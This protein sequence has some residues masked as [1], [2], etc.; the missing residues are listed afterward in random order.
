MVGLVVLAGWAFVGL[1]AGEILTSLDRRSDTDPVMERVLAIT[2]AFVGG[3]AG[4]TLRL[5]VFGETLGFIFSAAGAAA[6]IALYRSRAPRTQ[7][8]TGGTVSP[9]RDAADPGSGSIATRVVEAFAWGIICAIATAAAGLLANLV[10]SQLYPQRYEQIPS[11]L[12][13]IPLGLIVGFVPTFLARIVWYQWRVSQ[14]LTV[15]ALV[16]VAWGGLMFDYTRHNAAPPRLEVSVDANPANAI[17]CDSESCPNAGATP[18]WLVRGNVHVRSPSR[19]GGT[20]EAISLESYEEPPHAP[21]NLTRDETVDMSRFA[22]PKVLLSRRQLGGA[23]TLEP[24]EVGS[25]PVRYIY[26]TLH[27]D[28]ERAITVHVVFTDRAGHSISGVARWVVK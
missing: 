24:S 20:V 16:S 14:V 18:A 11:F 22:G 4:Q 1:I 19:V 3:F 27:G 28:S 13:F 10:G 8:R 7:L 26:R 25:Y 12:F 17:R 23:A 6:L 5:Y 21:K 9:D 15:I 2:G